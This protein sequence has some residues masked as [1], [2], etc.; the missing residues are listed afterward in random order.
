MENSRYARLTPEIG[1][2]LGTIRAVSDTSVDAGVKFLL[3]IRTEIRSTVARLI[4]RFASDTVSFFFLLLLLL[5]P[6][7]RQ[8]REKRESDGTEENSVT[9]TRTVQLCA[10]VKCCK[11]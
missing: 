10:C 6:F 11:E 9:V 3:V 4:S 2:F 7:F 5:Q 8:L 1:R